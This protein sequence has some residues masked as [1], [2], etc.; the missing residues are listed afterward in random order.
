M[1]KASF[2]KKKQNL[3]TREL[4]LKLKKKLVK[5]CIWI[6]AFF[7]AKTWT[8]RKVD[9]RYSYLENVEMWAGEKWRS[10]AAIV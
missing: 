6:I 9:R 2:D 5:C 7:G 4:G 10:V 3:F 8:L 1:A